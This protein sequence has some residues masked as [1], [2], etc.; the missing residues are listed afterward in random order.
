[1][2]VTRTRALELVDEVASSDRSV[3]GRAYED[4][5]EATV[6]AA[7]WAY[8][9]WSA[10]VQGLDAPDNR[11]RSICAQVLANLAA[12]SD[13]EDRILGDLDRLAAVMSDDR[14]VTARHARQAF[15]RVGLGGDEP[16]A[17]AVA[18]LARRFHTCTDEKHAALVRTDVIAALAELARARPDTGVDEV[19][20]DLIDE[21]PDAEEQ[22][23][24]RAAWQRSRA[25]P[26]PADTAP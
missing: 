4:L 21:E 2:P 26:M 12:H 7:P 13:P 24:Q 6:S 16:R 9:V 11:L 17:A 22:R 25:R 19:A 8:D 14:S 5:L 23:K 3:Q 15:W 18:A 1:M 10:V 20:H